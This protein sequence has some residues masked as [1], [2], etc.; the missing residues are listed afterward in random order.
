MANQTMTRFGYPHTL[1]REYEHWTVQLRTAQVTLG[2]LIL[3]AKADVTAFADLPRE[4]FTEQGEAVSDIERAL[5][6]TIGYDKVNYLMLMMVDPNVHYHVFPRYEGERTAC[7]ITKSD[8][9]W[10][11]PPALADALTL[12]DAA[13]GALRDHLRVAFGV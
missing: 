13:A 4:A 1:I 10:P 3:C 11:G 2:S 12:E 9:G 5:K 6:A 7:G 8:G